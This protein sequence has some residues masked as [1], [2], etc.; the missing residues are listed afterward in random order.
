LDSIKVVILGILQYVEIW[1][2]EYRKK[3]KKEEE[4]RRERERRTDGGGAYT[5]LYYITTHNN[6]HRL[7]PPIYVYI[8]TLHTY[9][10]IIKKKKS[11]S[12]IINSSSIIHIYTTQN[13]K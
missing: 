13:G 2:Y 11:V 6:T 8:Y 7:H 1:M 4:K 10:H 12:F 5:L 9:T 3:K